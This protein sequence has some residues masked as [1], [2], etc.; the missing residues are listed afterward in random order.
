MF[1]CKTNGIVIDR[2]DAELNWHFHIFLQT[3]TTEA[4]IVVAAVVFKR[5]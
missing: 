2:S 5:I 4:T 3:K 1:E